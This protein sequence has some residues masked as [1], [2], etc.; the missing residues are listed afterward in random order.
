LTYW[1]PRGLGGKLEF[2]LRKPSFVKRV[3]LLNARNRYQRG[4]GARSYAVELYSGA[5]LVTE[6][7]GDFDLRFDETP[8]IWREVDTPDVDK[9]IVRVNGASGHPAGL[10]E[11]RFE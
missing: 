6:V 2:K 11:F 1:A 10:A 8:W 7:T 4:I 3:G 5:D 9:I